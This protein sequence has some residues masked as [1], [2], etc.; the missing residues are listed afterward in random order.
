M[1]VTDWLR[2]AA[3]VAKGHA[4]ETDEVLKDAEEFAEDRTAHKY[5]QQL[6][7]GVEALERTFNDG[8][9]GKPEQT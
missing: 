9:E 8:K 3:N 1:G 6:E 5:D 2:K 7:E 4:V